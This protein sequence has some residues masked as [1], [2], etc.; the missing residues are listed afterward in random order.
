MF[1]K[2]LKR[3]FIIAEIGVNHDG[4]LGKALELIDVANAA[5]A[6]AVKFQTFKAAS[7]ALVE[8]PKVAYQTAG[9][10]DSETHFSMLESLELSTADHFYLKK[11]CEDVGIIFMSTP[12]D[13]ESAR[14]LVEELDVEILKVASADIVDDPLNRY[15]ASTARPVVISTGMSTLDEISDTLD[16]YR[17]AGS[18][19]LCLLHCV[20]SYP[21]S[22]S[23]VNIKVLRTLSTAFEVAV[24]FSD[25]SSSELAA[26]LSVAYGASVIEK[27]LTL[28]KDSPGPD[29]GASASPSEFNSY[30]NS[31]RQAEVILG[32]AV[33]RVQDEEMEMA[34]ISRK[35]LVTARYLK[36]GE[37]LREEHLVLRRPGYGLR[38]KHIKKIIDRRVKH[39][40]PMGHILAECDLE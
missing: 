25:H 20:S 11:Y 12:Y 17:E 28:S 4:D 5:G 26:L 22:D 31:I 21:C 18:S 15:L 1:F 32:T 27:H 13:C 40:L 10:S 35:S 38:S 23:S 36:K 34:T 7:L 14:F 24:G 37:V 33:K 3:C 29:H 8:T 30:V 2:S 9:T 6:D 16:I 19:D 39:D